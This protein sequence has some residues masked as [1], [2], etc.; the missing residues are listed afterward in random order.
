MAT[1]DRE[2]IARVRSAIA[3]IERL[4]ADSVEIVN[5]SNQLLRLIDQM[6]KP[7]I[8]VTEKHPSVMA[9]GNYSSFVGERPERRLPFAS[10]HK[11]KDRR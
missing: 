8:G 3:D 10:E 6:N 11:P 2:I 9:G 4:R 5:H 7:L 1:E